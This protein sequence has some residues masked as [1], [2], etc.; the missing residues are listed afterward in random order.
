MLSAA[1]L[2]VITATPKSEQEPGNQQDSRADSKAR[3]R[4]GGGAGEQGRG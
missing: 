4:V 1:N 3:G 2:I